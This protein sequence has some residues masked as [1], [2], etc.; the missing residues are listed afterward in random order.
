MAIRPRRNVSPQ[1][2]ANMRRNSRNLG[3]NQPFQGGLGRGQNIAPRGRGP[4]Q[5]PLQ[6]RPQCPAGQRPGRDPNTG[7]QTCVPERANIA[8]NVP[9]ING[10]RAVDPGPG[11]NVPPKSNRGY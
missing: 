9:V 6:N 3:Q 8:G 11:R 1:R 7:A 4:G 5:P 10:Q 2:T